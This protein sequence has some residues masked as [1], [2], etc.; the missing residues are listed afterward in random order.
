[1][2]AQVAFKSPRIRGYLENVREGLRE[3]RAAVPAGN[4]TATDAARSDPAAWHG[5]DGKYD[6]SAGD[7]EWVERTAASLG[8][9]TDR[10]RDTLGRLLRKRAGAGGVC[11]QD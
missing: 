10:Q 7:R 6:L 4:E 5:G 9:L 11:G 3:M 2:Q 8:P 1:M